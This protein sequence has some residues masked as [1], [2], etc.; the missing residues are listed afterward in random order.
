MATAFR[1]GVA[2]DVGDPAARSRV[3]YVMHA[4]VAAVWFIPEDMSLGGVR[5][6]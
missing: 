5:A 2:A 4:G 1:V 6:I 3:L